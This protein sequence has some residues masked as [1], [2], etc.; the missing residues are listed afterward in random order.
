MLHDDIP[1]NNHKPNSHEMPTE[2]NANGRESKWEQQHANE[3]RAYLPWRSPVFW[4]G[5]TTTAGLSGAILWFIWTGIAGLAKSDWIE[6]PVK[7]SE[8][9]TEVRGLRES[10][11][12]V[13][14]RMERV[15][16][17]V[18]TSA[19][20]VDAKLDHITDLLIQ[21]GAAKGGAPK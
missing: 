14:Q 16:K 21:G 1:L 11:T 19:A 7:D 20:K 4:A 3:A 6:K 13:E 17:H 18:E 12:R 5:V 8:F 10:I 9:R 2:H 15:E